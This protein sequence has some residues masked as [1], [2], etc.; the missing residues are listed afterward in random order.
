ML[1]PYCSAPLLDGA[2]F[3][4][5]CGKPVPAQPLVDVQP[6][7]DPQPPVDA[8]PPVDPQP[9]VDA[10]PPV[11]PQLPVTA[12][13]VPRKKGWRPWMTVT[14]IVL[15]SLAGAA[16]L[17]FGVWRVQSLLRDAADPIGLIEDWLYGDQTDDPWDDDTWDD[18]WYDWD[19]DSV[20]PYYD[21]ALE[22]TWLMQVE[23]D[24]GEDMILMLSFD[25]ENVRLFVMTFGHAD[26]RGKYAY[27]YDRA[28]TIYVPEFAQSFHY[29]ISDWGDTLILEPGI[30]LGTEYEEWTLAQ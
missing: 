3:C 9:P 21:D 11:D 13:P 22:N 24:D 26:Y 1:C 12:Q 14:V 28:D 4:G 5:A 23:G 16:A 2:K 10:Q 7:M 19:D 25:G 30:V 29:Y 18:D 15:A 17:F 20:G 27:E 6:P 8:Q